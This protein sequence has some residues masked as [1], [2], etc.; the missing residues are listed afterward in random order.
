[1]HG[2]SVKRNECMQYLILGAN[3]DI[4]AFLYCRLKMDGK[5]VT[6][7]GHIHK[8]DVC[9]KEKTAIVCIA[10]PNFSLCYGNYNLSYEINVV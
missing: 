1:M 7:T 6:G 9:D 4:G 10:Q 8:M 2:E 3:G 5:T